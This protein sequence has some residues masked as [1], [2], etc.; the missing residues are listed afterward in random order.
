[1]EE[2]LEENIKGNKYKKDFSVVRG[3]ISVFENCLSKSS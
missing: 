1:M 3:V 2:N